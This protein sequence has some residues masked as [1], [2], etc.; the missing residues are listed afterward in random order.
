[1]ILAIF[2]VML[3]GLI[4]DRAALAMS[5]I[6]PPVIY[7][8]FAAIFSV[9]SGGDLRIK[10]A[11]LDT[12]KNENSERLVAVIKQSPDLRIS[13]IIPKNI[14]EVQ[15]MVRGSDIDAGV[16]I[17]SDPAILDPKSP[18]SPIRVIGD[19]SRAIAG[20]IVAGHL[21]RIFGQHLPDIVYARMIAELEK[22]FTPL[23]P[24]QREAV[25]KQLSSIKQDAIENKGKSAKAYAMQ[26]NQL[27][28]Q[29][30]LPR[31]SMASPTVVYYAGAVG[32]MFLL[33]STIQ[34]GMTLI[35]ER[36]S[37]ILD[38]M[39]SRSG[40][41]ITLVSGKFLFLA[42]QGIVQLSL[43]FVLAQLIYNVDVTGRLPEWLLITLASACCAASLGL[44]VSVI[45]KTRSQASNFSNFGVLVMS[46][47][48]GSMVPRFLM[49]DWL[50]DV[51]WFLPNAWVIEAY[52][53]LLWQN[54]NTMEI[55]IPVALLLSL[56]ICLF[57][58][59]ILSLQRSLN[60]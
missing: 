35:D 24:N 41:I 4:R 43:I 57:G 3:L 7:I 18:Q 55:F 2:R 12:I 50:Q 15:N 54:A 21:I 52:N 19:T 8:I 49:P 45:F 6:L 42:L 53:S 46:A 9:T 58:I 27:V 31:K 30:N 28:D 40:S 34:G 29:I 5:F 14:D 56:S 39:L 25:Q 37:G 10:V 13:T 59:S 22:N 16:I 48:G 26:R 33:F 20:P 36:Q 51:S 1:M 47:I 38:R 23:L 32:F 60:H 17:R 44:L 11:I